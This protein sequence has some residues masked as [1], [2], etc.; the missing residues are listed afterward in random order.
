MSNQDRTEVKH[1]EAI[2]ACFTDTSEAGSLIRNFFRGNVVASTVVGERRSD[3]DL[4]YGNA[5]VDGRITSFGLVMYLSKGIPLQIIFSNDPDFVKFPE[6]YKKGN[7]YVN[8]KQ[9][10]D[11]TLRAKAVGD[12]L[13]LDEPYGVW[14]ASRVSSLSTEIGRYN[15]TVKSQK[16]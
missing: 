8:I 6:R 10:E 15:A 9:K 7:W 4:I 14:V 12:G 1:Y 13:H 3:L 11:K 16:S 2:D 5:L